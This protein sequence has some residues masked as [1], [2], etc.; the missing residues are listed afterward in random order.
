MKYS[1]IRTYIKDT[2]EAYDN[3]FKEHVDA[4]NTENIPRT[5]F[6]KGFHISYSVPSIDYASEVNLTASC[7]ANV[8]FYFKG[9]RDT[10]QAL[11]DAMNTV[12]DIS[13]VLSSVKNLTA[14]RATDDFPIQVLYPI[15]QV[16][17]GLQS[18]DNSMIIN[19]DLNLEIILPIC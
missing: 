10:Q 15:S 18:N 8:T 14:F 6:N 4:F 5:N 1:K 16:P 11:D 19:L 7:I 17:E 13:Q 12:C 3:K 9:Y 2:I